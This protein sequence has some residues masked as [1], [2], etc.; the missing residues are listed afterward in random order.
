[1]TA[2]P[3]GITETLIGFIVLLVTFGIV[4]F[5]G[6]PSILASIVGFI[7]GAGFYLE[8]KKISA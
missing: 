6:A 2:M 8:S 5:L 7:A 1:M 3:D 4:K